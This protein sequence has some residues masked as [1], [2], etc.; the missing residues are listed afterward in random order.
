MQTP[1]QMVWF[2]ETNSFHRKRTLDA[3]TPL[4]QK[5]FA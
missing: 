1:D 2:E 5:S 3:E 4:F